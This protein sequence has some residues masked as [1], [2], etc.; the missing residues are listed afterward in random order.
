MAK[1]PKETI[2]AIQADHNTDPA[3][4]NSELYVDRPL[5]AETDLSVT[6]QEL[7]K[8]REFEKAAMAIELAVR[9]AYQMEAAA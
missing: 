8:A 4:I 9:R 6:V 5:I 7:C 3:D 1:T 2:E